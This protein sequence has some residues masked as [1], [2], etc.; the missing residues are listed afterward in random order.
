MDLQEEV[1]GQTFVHQQ[2]V[3]LMTHQE[4]TIYKSWYEIGSVAHFI[5]VFIEMLF[6]H[7]FVRL[8]LIP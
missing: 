7:S 8:R 2:R 3:Q 5:E 6:E 4:L 1:L